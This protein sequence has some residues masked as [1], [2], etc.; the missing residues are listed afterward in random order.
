MTRSIRPPAALA[1][2]TIVLSVAAG[3]VFAMLDNWS[4][5]PAGLMLLALAV[6]LAAGAGLS[7]VYWRTLDEAAREAHKAAWMWGG[8]AGLI[9]AFAAAAWLARTDAADVLSPMLL[10]EGDGG[11]LVTGVMFT[12][13][14]QSL[15]YLAVWAWWWLA[16]R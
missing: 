1:V 10:S 6:L 11:W 8:S 5:A 14:L 13:V 15:G 3:A 9:L 12:L 16:R 2:G 7:V 4:A